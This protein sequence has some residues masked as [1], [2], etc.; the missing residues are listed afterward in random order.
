MPCGRD[1][2]AHGP[3]MATREDDQ[4]PQRQCR[5][6]CG[7][8][9]LARPPHLTPLPLR[10]RPACN[11]GPPPPRAIGAG[12]S[13]GAGPEPVDDQ[14]RAPPQCISSDRSLPPLR[15]AEAG[16]GQARTAGT[17]EAPA[18]LRASI[19]RRRVA[20]VP[21]VT[22]AGERPA[23][24]A[25]PRPARPALGSRVDLPGDLPPR[26]RG[27]G[28]Q[29]PAVAADRTPNTPAATQRRQPARPAD[30]SAAQDSGLGQPRTMLQGGNRG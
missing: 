29:H 21:M 25:L 23:S 4:A 16:R 13:R 17:R 7:G 5:A 6:L 19:V 20:G 12:N 11:R 2:Q 14:P 27:P 1:Q 22:G 28:P 9:Q 15:G 24:P 3:E 26:A 30:Q 10:G 18:G 8:D